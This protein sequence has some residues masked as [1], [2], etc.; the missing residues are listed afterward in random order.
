M[1]FSALA[2]VLLLSATVHAQDA[3]CTKNWGCWELVY[4]TPGTILG[5]QT[6]LTQIDHGGGVEHGFLA[7]YSTEHFGTLGHASAH[8]AMFGTIGGGSAGNEGS[9]GGA[10][11][12]GVRATVSE[13]SGPF[14]RLGIEGLLLGNQALYVSLLEPVQGRIGYQLLDG[15]TLLEGGIT[16]GYVPTGRFD[17]GPGRRDLSDTVEVGLYGAVQLPLLR[18]HA[19]LMH[20]GD[21][22]TSPGSAVNLLRVGACGYPRALAL[23]TEV[24]YIR[25][26]AAFSATRVE[27]TSAVYAGFTVGLTP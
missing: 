14:L 27:S 21:V 19:S 10:A 7:A 11:D 25:A 4:S 16:V 8:V 6:A 17:P 2:V 24:M 13:T 23:C 26:D 12:F 15:A 9:L 22:A 5:V 18:L 3:G 1:R 20:L